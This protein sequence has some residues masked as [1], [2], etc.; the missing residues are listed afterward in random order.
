MVEIERLE[1]EVERANK[2][3]IGAK[4]FIERLISV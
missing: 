2:K 1:A 4:D 3:L